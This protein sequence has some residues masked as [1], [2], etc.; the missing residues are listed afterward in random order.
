MAKGIPLGDNKKHIKGDSRNI[1]PDKQDFSWAEVHAP[2]AIE[3]EDGTPIDAIVMVPDTKYAY[4][5]EE[6]VALMAGDVVTR[7]SPD[8]DAGVKA[9]EEARKQLAQDQRQRRMK[10]RYTKMRS[11]VPTAALR[12]LQP[13]RWEL[14]YT[15]IDPETGLHTMKRKELTDDEAGGLYEDAAQNMPEAQVED[16]TGWYVPRKAF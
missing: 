7:K 14:T 15:V 8:P 2:G 6:S 5:D 1:Y 4:G 13:G 12:P 16:G 3:G 10:A 11:Q 9:Y